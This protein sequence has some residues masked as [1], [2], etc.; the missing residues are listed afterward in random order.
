MSS[1]RSRKKSKGVGGHKSCLSSAVSTCILNITNLANDKGENR[2]LYSQGQLYKFSSLVARWQRFFFFSDFTQLLPRRLSNI[3]LFYLFS[4][5]KYLSL[6]IPFIS[7]SSSLLSFR[8]FISFYAYHIVSFKFS[9]L[10][11]SL[12]L[13]SYFLVFYVLLP[14]DYTSGPKF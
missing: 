3:A 2:F 10:V 6:S 1:N 12:M 4:S 8:D 13:L 7:L 11:S 5:S 14:S 9:L